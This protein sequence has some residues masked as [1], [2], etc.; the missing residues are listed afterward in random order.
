MKKRIKRVTPRL[1]AILKSRGITH[2]A[3]AEKVGV[4]PTI[5]RFD[6][7]ERHD[8]TNLFRIAQALDLHIKDLFEIEFED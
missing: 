7:M 6:K 2:A 1:S 5:S 3:F 8:D 4:Q